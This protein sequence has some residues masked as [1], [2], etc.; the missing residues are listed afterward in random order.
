M[1]SRF[2]SLQTL[3]TT[4]EEGVTFRSPINGDEVRL[5]PEIAMRAQQNLNSDIAM[6][7]DECTPQPS[8]LSSTSE[9]MWRSLRWA[10]LSK[11]TYRGEGSVFGIVQGGLYIDLRLE[12]LERL[13]GIGFDGYAIGGLSV[14]ETTEEMFGVLEA[15]VPDMPDYAPRY[16]MG[17]GT[18][19]DLV[20]GVLLGIDMFDCVLP[21]RNA[22]NGHLCSWEGLVRIRNARYRHDQEPISG[23]CCCYACRH[24]TRA[25][26]H[27]LDKCHEMLGAT[28]MT[29][30]N[31]HFY[32]DLMANMRL[33]I[34]SGDL[35]RISKRWLSDW[36]P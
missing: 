22:R 29:I 19:S 2:F 21:T 11:A 27:H 1:G 4:D 28:L 6:V 25:Y 5:T 31:L 14:G 3:R 12:C 16:L 15:L 10:E 18:P 20:K 13:I 32:H 9:S 8:T 30:H 7:F 34:E 33:H 35:M 24:F 36:L 26:L 17:V 23:K